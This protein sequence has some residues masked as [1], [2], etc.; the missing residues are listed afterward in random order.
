MISH[1]SIL[2]KSFCFLSPFSLLF[3]VQIDL[4]TTT[5]SNIPPELFEVYSVVLAYVAQGVAFRKP[6]LITR[7][8]TLLSQLQDPNKGPSDEI[9][10]SLERGMCALLMGDLEKCHQWLGLDSYS[11]PHRDQEV[12]NFIM[13]VTNSH[14]NE[15]GDVVDMLPGLCKL[16]ETWLVQVVFPRSRDTQ[17]IDFKLRDYY[18]DPVV[19][20][21]LEST[22]GGSG[23]HLTAVALA[24][25]AVGATAVKSGTLTA[26]QKVFPGIMKQFD[27]DSGITKD[28]DV[29]QEN[30]SEESLGL[31]EK[32]FN[33]GIYMKDTMIMLTSAGVAVFVLAALGLRFLSGKRHLYPSGVI[34]AASVVENS[35]T[36][37][38][39]GKQLL[40]FSSNAYYL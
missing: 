26:F 12:V 25:V 8:D 20:R 19:L 21:Y 34:G 24:A 22:G 17:E 1:T 27:G 14:S 29:G 33:L 15:E 2:L 30:N 32:S 39:V 7:A 11:S 28:I 38:N 36:I 4:Y 40:L 5:P 23:S 35:S 37:S 13:D 18:D 3:T 6:H 31:I 10:F 16:L 9:E